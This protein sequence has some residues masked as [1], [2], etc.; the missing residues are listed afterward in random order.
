MTTN[1]YFA[2]DLATSHGFYFESFE[3]YDQKMEKTGFEEVEI[4][5]IDGDNAKLW[6]AC[7]ISQ[8][9]I[10]TWFDEL[11]NIEDDEDEAIAMRYLL[12]GLDLDAAIQR[13]DEVQIHRGTAEDYAQ[14]LIEETTDM[15]QIPQV[16][17]WNIDWQGIAND[18]RING[19]IAEVQYGVWVVNCLDF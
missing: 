12:D 9:T 18:M 13:A 6:E 5:L 2:L 8:A 1:S 16:I 11:E 14:D 4:Q 3:E 17:Q 19:E 15:T 7:N 10:E